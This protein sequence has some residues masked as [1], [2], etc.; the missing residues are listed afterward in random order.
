MERPVL[1]PEGTNPPPASDYPQHVDEMQ[2]VRSETPKQLEKCGM[3][4]TSGVQIVQQTARPVQI[5][6]PGRE[7]PIL[8]WRKIHFLV[9]SLFVMSSHR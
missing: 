5:S 8:L 6:E 4:I 7:S 9:F 2:D 1:N 3:I